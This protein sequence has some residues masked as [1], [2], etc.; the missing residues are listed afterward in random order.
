M[1]TKRVGVSDSGRGEESVL[2]KFKVI[3]RTFGVGID[4]TKN[5]ENSNL[6]GILKKL[7]KAM[8]DKS[9]EQD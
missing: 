3:T 7:R 4:N 8:E 5:S 1:I 2:K 9:N 6:T